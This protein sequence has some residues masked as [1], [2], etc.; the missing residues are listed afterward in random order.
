MN[1]Q[2]F[3][4]DFDEALKVMW[5]FKDVVAH[6]ASPRRETDLPR[7]KGKIKNAL[8]YIYAAV[9]S[10]AIRR[11]LRRRVSPNLPPFLSRKSLATPSRASSAPCPIFF[12]TKRHRWWRGFAVCRFPFRRVLPKHW[13]NGS[14]ASRKHAN[15]EWQQQKGASSSSPTNSS[16]GLPSTR[17][18][19]RRA[20]RISPTHERSTILRIRALS[21]SSPMIPHPRN[22][23]LIGA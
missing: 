23:R 21:H 17:A 22:Q 16:A 2:R 14:P 10:A 5:D 9:H 1:A 7:G 8:V 13:E 20:P 11:V 18:P 4:A 3:T 6:S 15:R 12:R 19:M